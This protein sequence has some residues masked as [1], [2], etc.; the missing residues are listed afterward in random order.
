MASL[1]KITSHT[2]PRAYDN[3]ISF[4]YPTS[5]PL[6]TKNSQTA[7]EDLARRLH[8]LELHCRQE[9]GSLWAWF[10]LETARDKWLRDELKAARGTLANPLA[11]SDDQAR[12]L[13]EHRRLVACLYQESS[14][15][16]QG[17]ARVDRRSDE[18]CL[19]DPVPEA[20]LLD[21]MGKGTAIIVGAEYVP[22]VC[23]SMV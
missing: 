8:R 7:E 13:H 21:A 20:F 4:S 3:S 9:Y 10:F 16:E 22:P 2:S 23:F 12:R 1:A 15:L 6:R 17:V 19:I 14:L 11:D 18:A 5:D